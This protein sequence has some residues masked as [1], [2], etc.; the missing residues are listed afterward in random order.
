MLDNLKEFIKDEDYKVILFKDKVHIINYKNIIN[1]NVDKAIIAFKDVG[2][3]I[4]G[5]DIKLTK[6]ESKELLLQGKFKGININ[7]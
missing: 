4:I 3:E 7:E 1:I 2:V 6:L 5:K